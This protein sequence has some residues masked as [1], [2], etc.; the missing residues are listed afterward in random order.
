VRKGGPMT[1]TLFLV[2]HAEASH[3]GD[4]PGLTP[5][6]ERQAGRLGRRLAG[7]RFAA[8]EHSPLRRAVQT[9]ELVA[10]SLPGVPVG[11]SEHL[12]DLTAVPEPG[13]DS[14]YPADRLDWLAS[15]PE[16]E[17]DPGARRLRAAVEHYLADIAAGSGEGR[18]L[19]LITHA[20][21]LG[22]FVRHTLDAPTWRWI[23]LN[24]ANTGLTT[25]RLTAGRPPVL[26]GFNDVGHLLD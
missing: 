24:S 22:W 8:I 5:E 3:E 16:E 21:V 6:G 2:R 11:P 10:R 12:H 17:R 9:A 26:V 23:G 15:V 19:L 20:F 14:D 4:S 25:V 1:T 7:T 18:N 13:R